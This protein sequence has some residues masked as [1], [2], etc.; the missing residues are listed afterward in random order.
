MKPR[1]KPW[2]WSI[3]S[4]ATAEGF[5]HVPGSKFYGEK[6]AHGSTSAVSPVARVYCAHLALRN[7]APVQV[8]L[9]RTGGEPLNLISGPAS[10]WQRVELLW[11]MLIDVANA[12]QS[13]RNDIMKYGRRARNYRLGQQVSGGML[14]NYHKITRDRHATEQALCGA[15]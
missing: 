4:V 2:N 8:A 14:I 6:K 11:G 5:L 7:C 1:E 13:A 3:K 9:V 10:R 15:R 12:H